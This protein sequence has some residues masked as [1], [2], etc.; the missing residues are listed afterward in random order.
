MITRK[1]LRR[2]LTPF[3]IVISFILVTLVSVNV[4]DLAEQQGWDKLLSGWWPRLLPSISNL[5]P[6]WVYPVISFLLGVTLTIWVIRFVP[7]RR[8]T[9]TSQKPTHQEKPTVAARTQPSLTYEDIDGIQLFTVEQACCYWC[10]STPSG[11]FLIKKDKN[12]R[13]G[14]IE[15]TIIS[16]YKSGR[17]AL[18]SSN[19]AL[20][21]I[22]YYENSYVSR[23]DL[24]DLANRLNKKPKFLFPDER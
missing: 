18:D 20:S 13:I 11:S 24:I 4:E 3:T 8:P 1:L 22:G 2:G 6:L 14:V 10:D 9:S 7:E 23:A 16:E 17:L 5:D 21:S 15:Q 12:P 19:N